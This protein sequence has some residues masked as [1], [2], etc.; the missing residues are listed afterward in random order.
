MDGVAVRRL[1][2]QLQEN[3]LNT[4][5]WSHFKRALCE[6]QGN[7]PL[8]LIVGLELNLFGENAPANHSYFFNNASGTLHQILTAK[9][10][11]LCQNLPSKKG[12]F[13]VICVFKQTY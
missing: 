5:C 10:E 6:N 7:I 11:S 12:F 2:Q 13:V 3:I 4:C 9:L 8:L 1:Q